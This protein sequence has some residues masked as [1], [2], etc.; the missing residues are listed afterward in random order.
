MEAACKSDHRGAVGRGARNLDRIL[1]RLGP[2][3]E[4][5]RLVRGRARRESV[6]LLGERHIRFV[7]RY[8]EAGMGKAFELLLDRRHHLG[9]AMAAIEHTDAA[10]EIDIAFAFDVPKLGVVRLRSKDFRGRT[11]ASRHRGLPT[12]QKFLIG[13]HRVLRVR[14]SNVWR[15][16]TQSDGSRARMRSRCSSRSIT[17][18][19]EAEQ[20]R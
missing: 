7:R 2:G 15:P 6:E 11:H 10:G 9:V 18:T 3:G 20:L 12:R 8:L 14:P 13:R 1:N 16:P 17:S 4:E 19:G 5:N